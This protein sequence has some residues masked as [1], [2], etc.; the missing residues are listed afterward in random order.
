VDTQWS[1]GTL[2]VTFYG[3]RHYE[4]ES[5]SGLRT[6]PREPAVQDKV[7]DG[8]GSCIPQSG[9]PEFDIT[10]TRVFHDLTSGAVLR[11][12]DFRTHYAAEAIIHCIAPTAPAPTAPTAPGG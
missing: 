5:V 11:S 7:D 6:N 10:V 9:V 8:S 2:T 4:I 1:P 12:E 3:T